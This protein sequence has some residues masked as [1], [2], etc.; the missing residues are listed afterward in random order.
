MGSGITGV[1]CAKMGRSFSGIEI[2]EE[3]FNIACRRVENAYK[4]GDLFI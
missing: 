2:D 1:A 3:Y 4:Q